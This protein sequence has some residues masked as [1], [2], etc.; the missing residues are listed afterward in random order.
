MR[1][2]TKYSRVSILASVL[3]LLLGSVG[4]FFAVR[5]VLQHQLDDTIRIEED[6]IIDNVTRSGQ[7]PKPANYR[8]Q[9]IAFVPT[10]EP[11]RRQFVNTSWEDVQSK[12][13]NVLPMAHGEEGAHAHGRRQRRRDPDDPCRLL[14]FPVKVG[15]QYYAAFVSKS[16]EEAEDLLVVIMYITAGMILLM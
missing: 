7:L 5:Y 10:R 14:V 2:F 16:A 4:Y 11:V 15:D 13:G 12:I 3:A 9:Q 8:D 1:L 6:E